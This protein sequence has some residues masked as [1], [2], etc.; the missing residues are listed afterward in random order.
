MQQRANALREAIK[1]LDVQHRNVPI[2]RVTV[3]MGVALF[4]EHGR[5]GQALLQAADAALYRSKDLGR[6]RVTLAK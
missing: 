3:S 5:T 4:P 2:G 6:D 1:H